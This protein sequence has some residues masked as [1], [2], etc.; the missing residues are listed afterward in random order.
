MKAHILY[1]I[2]E[3]WVEGRALLRLLLQVHL[4]VPP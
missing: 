2:C 4:R 3:L 1:T